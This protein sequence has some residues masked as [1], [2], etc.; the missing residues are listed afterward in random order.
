MT[1]ARETHQIIEDGDRHTLPIVDRD[2]DDR[3]QLLR[4][5][6]EM[7][8]LLFDY[9]SL[10]RASRALHYC[11]DQD[12]LLQTIRSMICERFAISEPVIF[13]RGEREGEFVYQRSDRDSRA[14]ERP[15]CFRLT[16]GIIWE[17]ACQGHP[18]SIVDVDGRERFP[19]VFESSG[20]TRFHSVLWQP[21][22]M[23]SQPV[24][25][26]ALGPKKSG[27]G[28]SH[29]DEEF[30]RT[31]GEQAAV[32]V[33]SLTLYQ[34][35]ESKQQILD[36]TI[37]NLSVLYDISQAASQVENMNQLL[38]EILDRAIERVEAQRGSIIL[39]DRSAGVLRVQV[40]RGLEEAHIEDAINSGE[41]DRQTFEPGQG[42][43]GIVFQNREPYIANQDE[44][45][46]LHSQSIVCLPLLIGEECIGVLNLTN[47][48]GGG[49]DDDDIEILKAISSQTA[50]TI[51]KADLYKLAVTDELTGLYVR[52]YM[53]RRIDEEFARFARYGAPFSVLILDVD[54]F[55]SVNDT[56]GH[57]AGD[58]VLYAV[59]R[60]LNEEAR[61]TDVVARYGGEEFVVLLPETRA[62]GA[63]IA[64]ER[65]RRLIESLHVQTRAGEISVTVS[66][67]VAEVDAND[68]DSSELLKRADEALYEAKRGGRN[69]SRTSQVHD[70]A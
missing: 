41:M 70:A 46:G 6:R 62:S 17:L 32:A 3:Q 27:E 55:K 59:A 18:I 56:H 2:H 26:I 58:A 33:S 22:V 65:L 14:P 30:L 54:H 61:E 48:L 1:D 11:K 68:A 53:L 36:R 43:A 35:L 38:L 20:L 60:A 52:R 5:Q 16:R 40:V 67:G 69:R 45:D 64:A 50:L 39:F 44:G 24:G 66:L 12:Q 13:L 47:K 57:D 10:L 23:E 37:R 34:Q 49:F 63:S 7:D 19:A 51:Q 15:F 4:V 8:A 25:I 9:R 42:I 29:H 28:Y 31:L 21:M